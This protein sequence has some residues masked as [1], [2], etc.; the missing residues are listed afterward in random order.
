[1]AP[2]GNWYFAL[3]LISFLC[4]LTLELLGKSMRMTST[5]PY[6]LAFFR[7]CKTC[8][9]HLHL[10]LL[11]KE[12]RYRTDLRSIS[13]AFGNKFTGTIPAAVFASLQN[14]YVHTNQT[15]TLPPA[16]ALVPYLNSNL[17]PIFLFYHDP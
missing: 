11:F 16:L 1:M 13:Y 14:V 9:K 2:L 15:L 7:G 8:T 5:E 6:L 4:A 10:P 3:S 17:I 12:S